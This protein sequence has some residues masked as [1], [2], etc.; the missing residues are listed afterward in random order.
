[1]R[2]S[3]LEVSLTRHPMIRY[4][5]LTGLIDNVLAAAAV[6]ADGCI[7]GPPNFAPYASQRLWEL[8]QG[9]LVGEN[10]KEAV[11]LQAAL[12]RADA[13]AFDAGVGRTPG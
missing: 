1:M 2:Y 11:R 3:V 6:G 4:L 7:G 10:L 9:P 12:A 13:V 8:S 5:V